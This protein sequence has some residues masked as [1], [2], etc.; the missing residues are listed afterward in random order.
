MYK[1][2]DKNNIIPEDVAD[3]IYSFMVDNYCN[4]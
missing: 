3:Q 1:V 2:F 4:R